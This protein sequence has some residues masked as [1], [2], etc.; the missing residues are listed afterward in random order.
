M[1]LGIIAAF[2]LFSGF[3]AGL[4]SSSP[5]FIGTTIRAGVLLSYSVKHDLPLEICQVRQVVLKTGVTCTHP[6]S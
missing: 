5:G 1:A 2:V 6:T 3:L 4:E